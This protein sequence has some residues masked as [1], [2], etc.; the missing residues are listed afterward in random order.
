M[1][2]EFTWL[3]FLSLSCLGALT[4]SCGG[5][6]DDGPPSGGASNGGSTNASGGAAAGGKPS[7]G[8]SGTGGGSAQTVDCAAVCGRVKSL[9]EESNAVSDVWVDAC[10]S[11]CD[12][13]VQLTP[14][15][16]E[17]EE[18]CV[19]AAADCRTAIACV[20]SPQ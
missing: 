2:G 3:L 17:L 15:V 4:L 9:C 19:M 11:A 12:A 14:D 10:K 16:A 7:G 8:S 6:S 5:D 18:A 20:A 13:R 1:K